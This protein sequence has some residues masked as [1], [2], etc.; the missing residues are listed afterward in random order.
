KRVDMERARREFLSSSSQTMK[1]ESN[2]D[3][4]S[5]R[6]CSVCLFDLHLSAV[7]CHCSSDRYAC[8]IHAKNFCSC[9]WGSKFFLYRYDTS[10]LNILVEALEGKLSAVYR[11]ARLD[12]GLALSSFISRDNMDFDKLSHSMD[13]PVL[14]M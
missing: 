14:K 6:E 10:E 8:L 11:W 7:G 4:T 1:M 13:G 12:L 3:A 2:F 9:A 5:E